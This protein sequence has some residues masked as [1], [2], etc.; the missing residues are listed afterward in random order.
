MTQRQNIIAQLRRLVVHDQWHIGL[1]HLDDVR[2]LRAWQRPNSVTW[3]P[4]A[5]GTYRADPFIVTHNGRTAVYYEEYVFAQDRGHL[6]CREVTR[7]ADGSIRFG[8]ALRIDGPRSH[9]S[10]P[11][12]FADGDELWMVPE[13]SECGNIM[14][15]TCTTFPDTWEPVGELV[16]DFPGIDPTIVYHDGRYWL[17]ATRAD[18]PNATLFIFF[19]DTLTGP[20]QPHAQ[21]PA[22]SHTPDV[23]PAG[24]PFVV[25]DT[26]YRPAQKHDP[27]RGYGSTIVLY[28]IDTL[29]PTD[30]RETPVGTLA[31][32]APH[33]RG[34]HT[35]CYDPASQL[36]AFDIKTKACLNDV[37]AKL[38]AKVTSHIRRHYVPVTFL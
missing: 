19:A 18:D 17:F 16:A 2:E 34:M 22:R 23:R 27:V 4:V 24:R 3:M 25:D 31:P 29:T 28:R 7:A 11:Y 26:L 37:L 36:C 35:V 32:W 20:W 21:Y 6:A 30:F 12:V 1:T 33:M 15:Y 14:L 13:E 8:A 5:R 9:R 38:W 10:Y